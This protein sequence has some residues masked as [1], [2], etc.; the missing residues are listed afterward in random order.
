MDGFRVDTTALTQ[1]GAGFNRAGGDLADASRRLLSFQKQLAEQE[2]PALKSIM[3]QIESAAK[4]L[5]MSS[6]EVQEYGFVVDEISESYEMAERQAMQIVNALGTI[7]SMG[8]AASAGQTTALAPAGF[9]SAL[10]LSAPA[11]MR[12]ESLQG[13]QWL[14]NRAI[15]DLDERGIFM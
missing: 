1:S 12:S 13:E 3:G 4:L 11:I 14:V 6:D 7:G 2:L 10:T 9:D 8:F 15:N 5:V